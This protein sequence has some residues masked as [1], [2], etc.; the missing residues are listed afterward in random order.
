M[1]EEQI[2]R[3]AREVGFSDCEIEKC[4]LMF[5]H[6]AFLVARSVREEDVE[7]ESAVRQFFADNKGE[8]S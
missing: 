4:Q 8:Q 3:I 2:T 6:F 7:Y 1:T 5:V